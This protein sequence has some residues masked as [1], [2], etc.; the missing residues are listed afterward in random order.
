MP[1]MS[2]GDGTAAGR[3]GE[4]VSRA[5]GGDTAALTLLLTDTYNRLRAHLV[6]RVPRDLHATVDADDVVQE[7][8]IEAFR[9]IRRFEPRGDDAF[10]RW[11]ATIALRRLRNAIKARRALK[12][13]GGGLAAGGASPG[14]EESV[15]ALL[16]LMAGPGDT[17]SREVAREEALAAVRAALACL[18]PAH[19]E[20]VRLVYLEGRSV[21]DAAAA[22]HRTPRAIHNLCGKAKDR[23]RLILGTR[24]RFLSRCR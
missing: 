21:A 7:T 14:I 15:V 18:P 20:A 9:H 10:Y 8:Q 3:E 22:M 16:D 4:L 5:I 1:I 2:H 24:S 12:R 6:R 13:C 17:P 11:L 23:L 19:Q